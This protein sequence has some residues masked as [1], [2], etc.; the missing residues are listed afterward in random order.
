MLGCA[1]GG[2]VCI[3]VCERALCCVMCVVSNCASH[4]ITRVGGGEC[5]RYV[6]EMRC[7]NLCPHVASINVCRHFIVDALEC[8]C[9]CMCTI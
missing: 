1:L 3:L 5:D 7:A 9:K 2:S 6:D 4:I 8:V